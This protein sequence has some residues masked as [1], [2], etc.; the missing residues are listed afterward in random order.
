M[1]LLFSLHRSFTDWNLSREKKQKKIK[2]K[3]A[4]SCNI[5]NASDSLPCSILFNGV[6]ERNLTNQVLLQTRNLSRLPC[7]SYQCT[8]D[9][10]EF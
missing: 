6:G 7:Q 1:E 5:C 10:P 3:K 4:Y 2:R 8:L 9:L